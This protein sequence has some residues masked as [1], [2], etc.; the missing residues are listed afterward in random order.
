MDF[1]DRTKKSAILSYLLH[2]IIKI[3]RFAKAP[4]NCCDRNFESDADLDEND[5]IQDSESGTDE[6]QED[7]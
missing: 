5:N 6:E 3:V 2:P 4:F 7:P 1:D